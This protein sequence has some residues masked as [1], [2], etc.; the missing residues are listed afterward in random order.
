MLILGLVLAVAGCDCRPR[1]TAGIAG[2][3]R[4][5]WEGANGPE[6]GTSANVQFPV[7]AMGARREQVLYVRNIGLAPFTMEEFAKV[8]GSA[9]TLGLFLAEPNSAFEV[10]WAPAVVNPTERQPVTVVFMPPVTENER[11]VDYASEV[12]LRPVGA[13][14][15]RLTMNG[16][17]I[18]GECDVP[19]VIDFGSVAVNSRLTSN[20]SLRND[21]AATIEVQVDGVTGA[22]VG[23]FE[24]TG[25]GPGGKLRVQPNE[26]P[27]AVV[28]FAPTEPRDYAGEVVIRRGDSC[29]K[30][31]V[32]LKGRGVS[33]CLS[34]RAEPPDDV[35]GTAL[36]FGSFAPGATGPG[37]V[38]FTNACST[39]ITLS[40][41][42]TT[43][44]A[45]AV[46][47][48]APGDLT[49][50]FI[51]GAAR[52]ANMVWV[53]GTAVTSLEFRPVALGPTV[54]RLLGDSNLSAQPSV[55]I[56]L[57][58]FG[59]GPR[60]EVRPSPVFAIGRVG[61]TPGASPG[62][63]AQRTLRVANVGNRPLPANVRDNLHL[64][65]GS[66]TDYFSVRAITGSADEL[67]IGEWDSSNNA[68]AGTLNIM[69]YNPASGIEAVA[70]MAMA[71]PVRV[72][73][74]TPG[75]KEWEL[76]LYSNDAVTPEVS[77]RIT[78]EAV[79]A[80]PCHYTATPTNLAFGMMD[81]PQVK[82]LSFT[83][84]NL[85][86]QAT[87]I[88]YF[89]GLSLSPSSHD[90]FSLPSAPSDVELGA[91]QNVTVLV[92]AQP[93]RSATAPTAATG[94]VL[95]NVS[96]PGA[97][98]GQ[99]ALSA[100]LAPACL[101]FNPSPANFADTE[102]ECGS[103][104]RAIIISNTCAQTVT[105]NTTVLTDAANAPTG[106]GTCTTAT[107]C[108]QFIITSAP[109]GGAIPPGA[110]RTVLLR[111][112]PFVVGPAT[113][114][115]TVTIQQG[116]T[117]VPYSIAL[118]GTGRARTMAGCGV[119]AVCPGP[120]NVSANSTVRLAPTVMST[121]GTSCAWTVGSR[122]ATSSGTF[123]APTSCS[124]TNYFADVVGTHLVNFQVTDALGGSA[125]CVTPI[126]VTPN[127]DLWIELTW[128]RP[129]D[130]D[131]HLL[132]PNGGSPTSAS[133]WANGTWDCYYASRTPTWGT[134]ASSPSLDRDDIPGQGPENTRINSPDRSLSYAIGVHMFSWRASPS[135][136]TS[137][138]KLYCAGT[139][140]N[141]ST[142]TMSR[143]GDM[144]VVGTV[145][146]GA[147]SPCA[148]TA[149]NSVV[150][151]VP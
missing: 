31:P 138:V 49:Q 101:T 78:A 69:T 47:A 65:V 100:T 56:G 77:L 35:A 41:L 146:F 81:K 132:H 32:Q 1:K 102:L 105:L 23:I 70:G 10:K 50:L 48:A 88:C 30:R 127:G 92:R 113:G 136:V 36:Y 60:I 58:G 68:C 34:W 86:S 45:F 117:A 61:F 119:T 52:D 130:M 99:V 126:T 53:S 114:E 57:R 142:K 28:N 85:G 8:S 55:S 95:F 141:T 64:R 133:S 2:E 43:D 89:N 135:P 59:G 13:A 104:D 80:P 39:P 139:L 16:R 11:L 25:L 62:T 17:A 24:I 97:S 149:I 96:T 18:A 134:S 21:G 5:E 19:A 147:G 15:S 110:S 54:G 46:T 84:Q 123:S 67:C 93:L 12:E 6:D 103:P 29:P 51:P 14:A 79:E 94:E 151:N 66:G 75:P 125:Q 150:P 106:S 122:P 22:P 112:R 37:T 20:V 83:L 131:L 148:F 87:E 73:P 98:Q 109:A 4:W 74:S 63:F 27:E 26:A 143:E 42:H 33:S 38:T 91:G 9:V 144:W 107:G 40:S 76:T 121:G 129:N 44:T 118:N 71:L 115:L 90:T 3:V 145:N 111:F 108:P 128:D 120:M 7:T 137:T 72:V 140:V 82:D 124:S 116:A